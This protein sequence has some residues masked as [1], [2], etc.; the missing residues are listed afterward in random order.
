MSCSRSLIVNAELDLRDGGSSTSKM[1]QLIGWL[2]LFKTITQTDIENL[3]DSR[4]T[5]IFNSLSYADFSDYLQRS[6]DAQLYIQEMSRDVFQ[7][8][9]ACNMQLF[10][11]KVGKFKGKGNKPF[12]CICFTNNCCE[13]DES[14]PAFSPNSRRD[15]A[16]GPGLLR[17]TENG[18]SMRHDRPASQEKRASNDYDWS[19]SRNGQTYSGRYTAIAVRFLIPTWVAEIWLTTE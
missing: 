1:A 3:W 4:I 6:P 16:R 7:D 18:I 19:A 8:Y 5:P 10:N 13:A 15:L 14:C 9:I 17:S 12:I 2:F 11:D